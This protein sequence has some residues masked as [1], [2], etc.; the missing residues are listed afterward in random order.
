MVYV[1]VLSNGEPKELCGGSIINDKWIVTA[2]HCVAKSS[3]P[4][5]YKVTV[6][7]IYF[8]YLV[9]TGPEYLK[10]V[11]EV[12]VHPRFRY[13]NRGGGHDIALLKLE[14]TLDFSNPNILPICM[15]TIYSNE[16]NFVTVAGWGTLYSSS[17][18]SRLCQTNSYVSFR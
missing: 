15:P 4:S 14:E 16:P 9:E 10:N 11:V 12:V 13:Y 7:T 17:I 18:W 3:N 5:D 8:K 6:G 2:A 1:N